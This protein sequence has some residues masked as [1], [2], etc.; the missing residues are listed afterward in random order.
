MNYKNIL[1]LLL[2][3]QYMITEGRKKEILYVYIYMIP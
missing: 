3:Y 1:V 2:L